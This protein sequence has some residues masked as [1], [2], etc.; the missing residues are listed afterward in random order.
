MIPVLGNL[1]GTPR[2]VA[3]G[4]GQESSGGAARSRQDVGLSEGAGAAQGLKDAWDKL[5][6]AETGAVHGAEGAVVGTVPG[7]GLGGQGK[8]I[9]RGC[10][11]S[12]AGPATWRRW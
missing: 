9:F 4:M 2:R 5:P 1:F 12:I 11:S 7:S 3:L 6:F 10:R 8:S